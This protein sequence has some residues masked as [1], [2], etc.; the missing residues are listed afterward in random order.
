MKRAL[1]FIS[2]YL[3]SFFYSYAQQDAGI[4]GR[5]GALKN[6]ED[7]KGF[8]SISAGAALP[9][10]EF[11]ETNTGA[12]GNPGFAQSGLTVMLNFGYRFIE[13]VGVEA[14]LFRSSHNLEA[15]GVKLNSVSP[16][17]YGGAL[18]G[19]WV[20]TNFNPVNFEIRALLGF[21]NTSSPEFSSYL[22]QENSG[23]FAYLIGIGVKYEFI[24]RIL[25]TINADFYNTKPYFGQNDFGQPITALNLCGGIGVLLF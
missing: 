7:H 4:P 1:I 14:S 21:V 3:L 18:A 12:S 5:S 9:V 17:V 13:N 24:D 8:L 15:D 2:F 25:F 16:W 22:I 20:T 10:G 6:R 23:S 19:P 11:G